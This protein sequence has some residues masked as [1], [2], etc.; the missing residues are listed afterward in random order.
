V[1]H[2]A[3][4]SSAAWQAGQIHLRKML[5]R[6][7]G[8]ALGP[9]FPGLARRVVLE[10]PICDH[11][12]MTLS[13]ERRDRDQRCALQIMAADVDNVPLGKMHWA[14]S[15]PRF[16]PLAPTMGAARRARPDRAL[17]RLRRASGSAHD[18]GLAGGASAERNASRLLK[19]SSESREKAEGRRENS[20]IASET[21]ASPL[22]LL[23]FPLSVTLFQQPARRPIISR[24]LRRPCAIPQEFGERPRRCGSRPRPLSTTAARFLVRLGIECSR[25]RSAL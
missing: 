5:L 18:A 7:I 21:N 2:V 1:S 22:S 15:D 19:N 12:A 10:R 23:P 17:P 25:G 6:E 9:A 13:P 3:R 14:W 16:A 20:R 8:L 11:L 4:G 24:A